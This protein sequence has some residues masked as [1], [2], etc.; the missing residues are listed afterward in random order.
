M[1]MDERE[2][3][4]LASNIDWT[5]TLLMPVPAEFATFSEVRLGDTTGLALEAIGGEGVTLIYE[6]N[7]IINM[8]NS[9]DMY[10]IE[11]LIEFAS[12]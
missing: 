11:S 1:G 12:Q 6:R 7:G 3:N 2:A 5:N 4:R 9:N 10:D 8:L